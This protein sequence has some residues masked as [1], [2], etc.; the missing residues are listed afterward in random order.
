MSGRPYGSFYLK[1]VSSS[2]N[3]FSV[4][5][6]L[7]TWEIWTF[8]GFVKM[9]EVPRE[10]MSSFVLLSWMFFMTGFFVDGSVRMNFW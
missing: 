2:W 6:P 10:M 7:L 3:S 5:G 4:G 1:L 8:L 9:P